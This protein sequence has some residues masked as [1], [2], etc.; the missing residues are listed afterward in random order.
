MTKLTLEEYQACYQEER[1]TNVE[2]EFKIGTPVITSYPWVS[3]AG[4]LQAFLFRLEFGLDF[5]NYNRRTNNTFDFLSQQAK[6]HIPIAKVEEL[7]LT[8]AVQFLGQDDT[9]LSMTQAKQIKFSKRFEE[10]YA[11]SLQ[12]RGQF[13]Q[14]N[15]G[16]LKSYQIPLTYLTPSK[17]RARCWAKQQSLETLLRFVVGLGKKVAYGY[18]RILSFSIRPNPSMGTL[19]EPSTKTAQA[20]LPGFCFD[21]LTELKP[22]SWQVPAWD[23]RNVG[24]AVPVG[25]RCVPTPSWFNNFLPTSRVVNQEFS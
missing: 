15:R 17:V 13:V 3:L 14:I 22:L 11:H 19:W 4:L 1:Y 24:L 20:V 5:Y 10:R 9:L 23:K 25:S 7:Y 12:P 16:S 2:I 8:S 6:L 18:G 21:E